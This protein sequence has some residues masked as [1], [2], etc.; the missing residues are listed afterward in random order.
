MST[1]REI[2]KELFEGATMTIGHIHKYLVTAENIYKKRN[3]EPRNIY[4]WW[5]KEREKNIDELEKKTKCILEL[6]EELRDQIDQLNKVS[7]FKSY[8]EII[9]KINEFTEENSIIINKLMSYIEFLNR[10]DEITLKML[11]HLNI[12]RSDKNDVISRMQDEIPQDDPKFDEYWVEFAV[13]VKNGYGILVYEEVEMDVYSDYFDSIDPEYASQRSSP[14]F[15]NKIVSRSGWEIIKNYSQFFS[16]IRKSM[17]K[18]L[19]KIDE[20]WNEEY[21]EVILEKQIKKIKE[22]ICK[23]VNEDI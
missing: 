12:W 6:L 5:I 11:Y 13:G 16:Y 21:S 1:F 19:E 20:Y 3:Y 17:R 22:D 14:D 8:S 2:H 4:R 23:K 9:Q 7:H 10:K 18:I 15:S